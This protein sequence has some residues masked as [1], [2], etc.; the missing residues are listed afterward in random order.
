MNAPAHKPVS[1]WKPTGAHSEAELDRMLLGPAI[2]QSLIRPECVL[3]GDYARELAETKR[4][5]ERWRAD[6][7]F[8][9]TLKQNA[10]ATSRLHLFRFDPEELRPIWDVSQQPLNISPRLERFRYWLFEK[11]WRREQTRLKYCEPEDPRHRRWRERQMRRLSGELGARSHESIVHAPV[12]IELSEGCSVGCWFCGVSA[13]KKGGDFRYEGTSIALWQDVLQVLKAKIGETAS[14]SFLYW[15]SDPLDNPDYEKFAL[16][17]SKVLGRFP[18]TTTA[19]AHRDV[20]R[21]RRLLNTSMAH[22]CRINRFSILSLGQFNRVMESFSPLELL[23]CEIVSQNL[24]SNQQQSSAGRALNHER[25]E[26]SAIRKGADPLAWEAAPGTIACVSGFLLN[27]VTRSLRLITPCPAD[28]R[29]PDGYRVLDSGRFENGRDLEQEM[30]RMMSHH[31]RLEPERNHPQRFRKGLGFSVIEEG[32][33]LSGKGTRSEFNAAPKAAEALR[34]LGGSLCAGSLSLNELTVEIEAR[35]GL[36]S[37]W[38]KRQLQ[39]CFDGGFLDDEPVGDEDSLS[40]EIAH[41]D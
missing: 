37:E 33:V 14:S 11:I 7:D 27:M 15:A 40:A 25:L 31:M 8:R 29:W 24:E 1:W 36:S 38:T 23:H 13:K 12:A 41:H 18:Q 35:F 39:S 32:F 19:I 34:F 2:L 21:T 20:E 6:A 5:V 30:E 4:F 16:D 26:K 28:A 9:E 3:D 10:A 17:F 22:G